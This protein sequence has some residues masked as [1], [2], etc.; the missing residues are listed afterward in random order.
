MPM[1]ASAWAGVQRLSSAPSWSLTIQPSF[2]N[3]PAG[4]Y[5]CESAVACQNPRMAPKDP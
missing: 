5:G 3:E 2:L 4:L 1:S